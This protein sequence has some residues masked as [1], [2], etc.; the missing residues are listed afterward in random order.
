MS[1]SKLLLRHLIQLALRDG[2]ADDLDILGEYARLRIA[3]A[4]VNRNFREEAGP[5]C[6]GNGA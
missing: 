6:A 2:V 4:A 3:P 5:P 1:V